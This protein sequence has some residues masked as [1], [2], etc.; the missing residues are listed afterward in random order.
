[1]IVRKSSTHRIIDSVIIQTKLFEVF[2]V[3]RDPASSGL[4]V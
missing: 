3:S 1:M 2:D 4:A